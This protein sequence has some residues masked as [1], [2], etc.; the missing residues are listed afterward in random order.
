VNT[1]A[2]VQDDARAAM[3]VQTLARVDVYGALESSPRGLTSQEAAARLARVGPNELPK[4]RGRPLV[5]RFFEQFTDLFAVVLLVASAITF[6]AYVVQV[7]H[8]VGNLQLAIAILGVVLLNAVIGFFQEYSA[9]RTSE[10]LKALV[11]KACRVIRDGERVE[12]PAQELVPGDLVT[13]EAGDAIS[14][15]CRVVEAHDFSVNNVAL[16]GESD[17]VGRTDD[18]AAPGTDLTESRNIVFMGTSVVNG[19]GVAVVFATG[20]RTEFG[21]IYRLTAQLPRQEARCSVR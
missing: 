15:D 11:P 8:D 6:V 4:A 9:E 13:L 14:C 16:T 3:P 18:P 10:A 17:P 7:P 1:S 20:L 2:L 21:R 5:F 12:I 19:T